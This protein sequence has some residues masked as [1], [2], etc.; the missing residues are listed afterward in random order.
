MTLDSFLKEIEELYNEVQYEEMFTIEIE[1]YNNECNTTYTIS[2][3]NNYLGGAKEGF[4]S[5]ELG[6]I[7]YDDLF[8][9]AEDIY[10]KTIEEKYII[11]NISVNS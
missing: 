5:G 3:G 11:E 10:N 1:L 6:F 2:S 9:I 4:I 8:E 7:Q